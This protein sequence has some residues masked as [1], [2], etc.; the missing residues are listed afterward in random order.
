[1]R[2]LLIVALTPRQ[3]APD[4]ATVLGRAGGGARRENWAHGA[5]VGDGRLDALVGKGAADDRCG[6]S[7]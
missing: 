5:T 4:R 1:M 7:R 2:F 3:G 6:A